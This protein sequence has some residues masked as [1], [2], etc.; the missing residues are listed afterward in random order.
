MEPRIEIY[1]VDQWK[2]FGR[3]TFPKLKYSDA[4]VNEARIVFVCKGSS[5]LFCANQR[6]QLAD[7]DIVLMKSDHF[8]NDWT[9]GDDQDLNEIIVFQFNADFVRFLYDGESPDWF[10]QPAEAT[11]HSL[12]RIE[13]NEVLTHYISSL[14]YYLDN[15]SLLNEELIKLKIRELIHALV[16]T[17]KSGDVKRIMTELFTSREYDFQAMISEHLYENLSIE[18]LAFM[19]RMSVSSFKRK[20]SVVYGTTPNKY[21]T[22]RR[23][24]KAQTLLQSSD[25][26]VSDIAYDCGFNDV[27]YFTKTFSK[28]FGNSPSEY[29]KESR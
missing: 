5:Q 17:D 20:F 11:E 3:R 21:I 25:L 4:L 1:D 19:G 2:V 8:V 7:G 18:E 12:L 26:R 27:G 14:K 22:S 9:T 23:L 13:S 24:E 28:H 15:P 6:V 16:E 10:K 29:R